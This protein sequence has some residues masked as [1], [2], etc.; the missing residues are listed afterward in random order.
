M[1]IFLMCTLGTLGAVG[2]AFE[3]LNLLKRRLSMRTRDLTEIITPR[4]PKSYLAG[5]LKSHWNAWGQY[6][7]EDAD[8]RNPRSR[9]LVRQAR[10]RRLGLNLI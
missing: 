5:A 7:R 6:E 3:K 2:R 1:P 10:M 4:R 9:Q 8:T